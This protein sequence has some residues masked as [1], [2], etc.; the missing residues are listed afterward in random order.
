MHKK[1]ISVFTFCILL[2]SNCAQNIDNNDKER[3]I[4]EI[5]NQMWDIFKNYGISKLP[6]PDYKQYYNQTEEFYGYKMVGCLYLNDGFVLDVLGFQVE[7]KPGPKVTLLTDRILISAVI[8]VKN[9]QIFQDFRI[10]FENLS[11]YQDKANG[12]IITMPEG[13]SFEVKIFQKY[14]HMRMDSY[15]Q[16]I[17]SIKPYFE[18]N[19]DNALTRRV[20]KKFQKHGVLEDLCSE[21]KHIF[22]RILKEAV[23]KCKF[24]DV[25]FN[26]RN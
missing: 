12:T 16:E 6:V 4:E 21:W 25:A 24:P 15:V 5:K 9:L 17:R 14:P 23:A 22:S 10:Q 11:D 18:F 13:F 2:P 1:I 20:R 7:P 3:Y 26:I 19:P 8:N